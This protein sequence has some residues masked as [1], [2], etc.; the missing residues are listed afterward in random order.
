MA[1]VSD[2]TAGDNRKTPW[3]AEWAMVR[4][5]ESKE[6]K[7]LRENEFSKEFQRRPNEEYWQRVEVIQTC[8]KAKTGCGEPINLKFYAPIDEQDPIAEIDYKSMMI[9][10]GEGQK[11]EDVWPAGDEEQAY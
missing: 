8:I 3:Y 7:I 6:I 10:P 5:K 1:I 4:Y 2:V 11:I 9:Q